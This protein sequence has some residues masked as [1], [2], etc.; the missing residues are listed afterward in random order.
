MVKNLLAMQETQ[1]QSLSQEDPLEKGMATRSTIFARRISWA[2]EPDDLQCISCKELD[3]TE[4]L[5]LSLYG[6]FYED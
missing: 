3:V 6:G 5:T 2:E 4:R 1:I